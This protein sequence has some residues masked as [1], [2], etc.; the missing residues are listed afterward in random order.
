T[1]PVGAGIALLPG[2]AGA[3]LTAHVSPG[4]LSEAQT[5]G[6]R[7]LV[8]TGNPVAAILPLLEILTGGRAALGLP[9]GQ[10]LHLE[11]DPR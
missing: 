1:A 9:G 2:G 11:I 4:Q 10:V 5:D 8:G 6:A 7:A 3:R